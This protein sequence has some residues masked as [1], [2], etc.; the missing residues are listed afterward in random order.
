[1][2]ITQ[3]IAVLGIKRLWIAF[4]TCCY[5]VSFS[6]EMPCSVAIFRELDDCYPLLRAAHLPS[7]VVV[8]HERDIDG[9]SGSSR[10]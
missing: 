7:L 5:S 2:K 9:W 10:E 8:Y 3:A 6:A 1:M 4:P